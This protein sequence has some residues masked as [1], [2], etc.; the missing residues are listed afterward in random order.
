MIHLRPIRSREFRL[1]E[2]RALEIDRDFQRLKRS[3]DISLALFGL[4]L[5]LPLLVLIGIAVRLDSSGPALFRQT[6][7]GAKGVSFQI[8]KFRTMVVA[9]D[10]FC[11][12]QAERHDPRVTRVGRIL[13]QTSLDELPQLLNVLRGEMSLVG[14]RPHALAHDQFYQ[15]RIPFYH[16]RFEVKPGITGWAQVNGARGATPDLRDMERR[17]TLDLWYVA[18]ADVRTDIHILYRTVLQ[19]LTRRTNAF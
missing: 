10:G 11:V 19:E 2:D 4:L 3:I 18:N 9:E 1:V 15:E 6:R 5:L 8:Y 16:K 12:R 14:P 13:R 17:V 7:T